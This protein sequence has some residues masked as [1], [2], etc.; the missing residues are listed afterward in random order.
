MLLLLLVLLLV[1][2]LLLLL[3]VQVH[4]RS[5]TRWA[6]WRTMWTM[7]LQGRAP[8]RA[9]PSGTCLHSRSSVTRVSEQTRAAAGQLGRLRSAASRW[10]L[11]FGSA[12]RAARCW[13][14]RHAVCFRRSPLLPTVISAWHAAPPPCADDDDRFNPKRLKQGQLKLT[15]A[16]GTEQLLLTSREERT[17]HGSFLPGQRGAAPGV[18]VHMHLRWHVCPSSQQ[19]LRPVLSVAQGVPCVP[20]MQ[21]SKRRRA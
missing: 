5:R 10:A 21:A 13:L 8:C 19:L 2:L 9:G 15:A 1:L 11:A 17:K 3:L 16:P 18:L 7:S 14:I 20:R 6:T 12:R 4:W